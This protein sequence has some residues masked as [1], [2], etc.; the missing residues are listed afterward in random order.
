M[1]TSVEDINET[2]KTIIVNFSLEEMQQ[3]HKAL[4]K[5][6]A[7]KAQV[8]GFRPGKAPES[9]LM[10]FY[11]KEL[12][13]DLKGRIISKSYDHITKDADL[14]IH[15]VVDIHPPDTLKP[16]A[17]GT[18]TF[19]VDITPSFELPEY[20]GIA[21]T[22]PKED[23]S[24][25]EVEQAIQKIRDQQAEYKPIETAAEKG[26]YVKTSYEGIINGQPIADLVPDKSIYSKQNATWKE[27]GIEDTPGISAIAQGIAG[28]KPGDK[29]DV[30][31]AFP[32]DFE[33]EALR[34]KEAS[35]SIEVQEVRKKILPEFNDEF[36][37]NVKVANLEELRNQIKNEFF[38]KIKKDSN[39]KIRQQ[40][41]QF[42]NSNTDFPI[43]ES[44]TDE[45]TTEILRTYMTHMSHQ[46][47]S[48]EAF[49][50][51]KEELLESARKAALEH[52][53]T[54]IILDA[55][56][57]KESIEIEDREV[58]LRIIQEAMM[59]GQ[60]PQQFAQELKKDRNRIFAIKQAALMN[61][62]LDF[63]QKEAKIEYVEE[64][65]N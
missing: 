63:I 11:A 26:D 19:T 44:A 8:K 16:N 30:S 23:V 35:Y 27:V 57:K 48:Q 4:L 53:K 13:E 34:G 38:N 52:A 58:N 10:N 49:E 28:M 3:E 9:V 46:G 45:E 31:M 6:Y 64:T 7:S 36:F 5:L 47:V 65:N 20:K 55:I 1:D 51:K 40:I 25:E 15:K 56:A 41:T 39:I 59:S 12:A 22:L 33:L 32:Q 50:E 14:S 37:K 42:I 60:K 54:N 17:K 18:I 62:V 61:K 29:K 2:R 21:V 43:P 24:E